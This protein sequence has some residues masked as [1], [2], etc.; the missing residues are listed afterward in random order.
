[1]AVREGYLMVDHR[2]SP[3]LPPEIARQAGYD[4]G[5]AGEGKLLE[6]GT[7]TCAHCRGTVVKSAH[8]DL[9]KHPRHFCLKCSGRYIC[10]ACH[11]EATM[12]T[13]SHLPFEKKVALIFDATETGLGSPPQLLKP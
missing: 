3:G 7:L 9:I 4:V 1:M 2:A 5:L 12:A 11:V 13:Y 10:D 6:V 8:R